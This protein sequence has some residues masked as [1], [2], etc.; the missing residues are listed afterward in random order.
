MNRKDWIIVK[1]IYV[2]ALTFM[3]VSLLCMVLGRV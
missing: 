2:V 1:A 3:G